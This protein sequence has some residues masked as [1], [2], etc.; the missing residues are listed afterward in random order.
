MWRILS[1][2]SFQKCEGVK[3]AFEGGGGFSNLRKL[4]KIV[5]IFSFLSRREVGSQRRDVA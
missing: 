3:I 5:E 4:L 1:I 2:S